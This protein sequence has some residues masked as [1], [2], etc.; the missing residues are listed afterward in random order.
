MPN[1]ADYPLIPADGPLIK[2]LINPNV[3]LIPLTKLNIFRGA[4]FGSESNV[5]KNVGNHQRISGH[6][7]ETSSI[8]AHRRDSSWKLRKQAIYS[9]G[10]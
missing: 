10:N 1:P 8:F 7:G 2:I 5:I 3:P 6:S 9:H 4:D